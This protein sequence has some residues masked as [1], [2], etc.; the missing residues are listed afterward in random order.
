MARFPTLKG[1]WPW[2][3]PL[4]GSCCIPSCITHRPLP[5]CQ[6]SLKSKKLRGRTDVRTYVRTDILRPALLGRLCRR[7]DLKRSLI[8]VNITEN[9]C[10]VLT[11]RRQQNT[12]IEAGV[13][14]DKQQDQRENELTEFV[15]SIGTIPIG[16]TQL[17]IDR[18]GR[19]VKKSVWHR[20]QLPLD[21][22]IVSFCV[23]YCPISAKFWRHSGTRRVAVYLDTHRII[24]SKRA[25]TTGVLDRW[26]SCSLIYWRT[27]CLVPEFNDT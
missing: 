22:T 6:I 25:F 4:I 18:Q 16:K 3:W 9:D 17:V 12:I 11:Q 10:Q 13:R 15:T 20:K 27:S 23:V 19:V 26:H 5:T 24:G 2:P 8:R 14:D 1:S 7:V 21:Q